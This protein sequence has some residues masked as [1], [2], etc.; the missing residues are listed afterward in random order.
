MHKKFEK[1]NTEKHW[2]LLW[3]IYL[4]IVLSIVSHTI[5]NDTDTIYNQI[6]INILIALFVDMKEINLIKVFFHMIV[7]VTSAHR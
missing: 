2:C 4:D 5:R 7:D 3:V 6:L 1:A